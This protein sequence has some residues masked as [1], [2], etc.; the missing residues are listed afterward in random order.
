[1]QEIS[2]KYADKGVKVLGILKDNQIDAA[3]KILNQK[4]GKFTNIITTDSLADGFLEEI[5]YTP[6]TF[7]INNNGEIL[8]GPI[9]GSR[10]TDEFSDIID[11]ALVEAEKLAEIRSKVITGGELSIDGFAEALKANGFRVSMEGPLVC[12]MLG[13][14]A[15]I[16]YKV[17]ST[18]LDV[19]EFDLNSKNP[20]TVENIKSAKESGTVRM[21]LQ[22]GDFTAPVVING[23][24]AVNGI[25]NLKNKEKALE[26]FN[27]LK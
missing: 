22:Q 3:K 18:T 13:A 1:M 26:I 27:G 16:K 6:T 7:L 24:I 23:N 17:N 9:A 12:D 15:G 21:Q 5:I 8:R 2:D 25:E 10:S 4:G 14:A 19:Y 20:L 11:K